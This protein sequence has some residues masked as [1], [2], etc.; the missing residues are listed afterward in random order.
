MR[1]SVRIFFPIW[2]FSK[3]LIHIGININVKIDENISPV[4][5]KIISDI[6]I[7]KLNKSP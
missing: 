5:I 2:N 4:S 1:P 6:E 7:V 3:K